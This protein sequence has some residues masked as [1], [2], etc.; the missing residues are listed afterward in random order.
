MNFLDLNLEAFSSSET[1]AMIYQRIWRTWI[2][3]FVI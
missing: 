1:S 3:P 2:F